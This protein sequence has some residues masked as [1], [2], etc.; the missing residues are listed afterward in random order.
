MA[1]AT[2]AV[3]AGGGE[4]PKQPRSSA[5]PAERTARAMK[6][7]T[8][9]GA[10]AGSTF[11][12]P[13]GA[14]SP[15]NAEAL[16]GPPEVCVCALGGNYVL[17]R[18]VCALARV[19]HTRPA[20][21]A[22]LRVRVFVV[23]LGEGCDVAELLASHDGWYRRHVFLPFLRPSFVPSLDPREAPV[24]VEASLG[25]N[26][27]EPIALQRSL[28][29]DY[30]QLAHH[31]LKVRVF[32]CQCW[33]RN[34]DRSR[35]KPATLTVPFCI[36]LELGVFPT[37]EAHRVRPH[38]SPASVRALLTSS[39]LSASRRDPALH[40]ADLRNSR[41][42][43][44]P[45]HERH[46]PDRHRLRRGDAARHGAAARRQG[47][48]VLRPHPPRQHARLAAAP[49]GRGGGTRPVAAVA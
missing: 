32:E 10:G 9:P 43:L 40:A 14:V 42:G 36:R 41:P 24:G 19:R 11:A 15:A 33:A 25:A 29:R 39:L 31:T 23:P 3:A 8:V 30:F 27:F 16:H 45:P 34:E 17:H 35:S 49:C 6:S 44:P 47:A 20:D 48:R 28:L 2:A 7:A 46:A 21:L 13:L 22:A 26:L 4:A 38:L 18:V 12:G 1:A 37:A 5:T